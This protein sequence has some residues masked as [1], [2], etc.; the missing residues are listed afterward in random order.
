LVI[1]N[2]TMLGALILNE[3]L[4]LQTTI[5]RL[6]S[7]C[8]PNDGK[9]SS[10]VNVPKITTEQGDLH[11]NQKRLR[12]LISLSLFFIGSKKNVGD[13]KRLGR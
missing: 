6:Y 1:S 10:R 5:S 7:S 3:Q 11:A 8:E 12:D 9:G 2:R 4:A 13:E